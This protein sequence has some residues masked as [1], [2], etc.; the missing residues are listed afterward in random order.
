MKEQILTPDSIKYAAVNKINRELYNRW[1]AGDQRALDELVTENSGLAIKFMH[2]IHQV[3][4][5]D[6]MQEAQLAMVEAANSWEPNELPFA[7]HALR[8][9]A[10]HIR[11]VKS[12]SFTDFGMQL[13]EKTKVNKQG[14]RFRFIPH[15]KEV[16]KVKERLTVDLGRKPSLTEIG[17]ECELPDDPDIV[18][19]L[20]LSTQRKESGFSD[21]ILNIAHQEYEEEFTSDLQKDIKKEMARLLTEKEA[22]AIKKVYGIG[23][24]GEA[25]TEK[26]FA[27]EEGITRDGVKKRIKV[28]KDKLR[29]SEVLESYTKSD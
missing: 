19:E 10:S 16:V 7:V 24:A 23:V 14:K 3:K 8:Q 26:T 9:V 4:D 27:E 25:M 28:A 1:K 2:S 22:K 20:L 5:E 15:Q 12:R 11:E 13:P 21:E 17:L 18:L 6:M 29:E